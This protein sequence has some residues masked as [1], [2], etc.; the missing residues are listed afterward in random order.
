MAFANPRSQ[1]ASS[2]STS[3]RG[4]NY[5][6]FLSFRGE[7]TRHTFTDHLYRALNRKWIRTFRD[8]E[9]LR[10][11]EEIAPELLKAIEESRICLIILSKNYARSRWCLEELAKIMDCREQMGKLVFPILYHV[12]PYSEELDTCIF[13]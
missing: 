5:D 8:T 9:E 6:V 3:T 10:R 4:W 2:S 12:D 11:G 1:R 7:D 13:L